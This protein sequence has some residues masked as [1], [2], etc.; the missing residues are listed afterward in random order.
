MP[1]TQEKEDEEPDAPC[2]RLNIEGVNKVVFED[3]RL[4]WD[5]LDFIGVKK[6]RKHQQEIHRCQGTE[7]RFTQRSAR[8]QESTLTFSI[9]TTLCTLRGLCLPHSSLAGAEVCAMGAGVHHRH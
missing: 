4:S 8:Q 2:R 7:A 9:S 1:W 3:L 6:V 5:E